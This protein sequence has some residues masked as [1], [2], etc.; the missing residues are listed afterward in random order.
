MDKIYLLIAH[1]ADGDV[2]VTYKGQQYYKT[3]ES[4]L[5]AQKDFEGIHPTEIVE[6][7]KINDK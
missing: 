4:A 5:E 6:F 3:Y 2:S 7:K 1:C